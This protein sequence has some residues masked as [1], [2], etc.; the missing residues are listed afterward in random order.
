M[1]GNL[2]FGSPLHHLL[3]YAEGFS[4]NRYHPHDDDDVNDADDSTSSSTSSSSSPPSSSGVMS[5]ARVHDVDEYRTNGIIDDGNG[6]DVDSDGIPPRHRPLLLISYE[7]MKSNLREEVLRIIDFLGLDAI[8]EE[9]LDVDILPKFDFCYMKENSKVF[10]PRSVTWLN[11]FQ[12]LRMGVVGDGRKKMMETTA[13][14]DG[15]CDNDGSKGDGS[16][17]GKYRKWVIA[18]KYHPRIG[19][20]MRDGLE[21]ETAKRFNVAVTLLDE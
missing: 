15:N 8:P 2:P 9:A 14:R 6:N 1:D 5:T 21:L 19:E 16:L 7:R 3:S 13:V 12:F 10:Q 4:V 11:G 20:L 17:M 18:E